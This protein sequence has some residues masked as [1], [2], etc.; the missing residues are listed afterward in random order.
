MKYFVVLL[1]T[2]DAEKS[3]EYRPQHLEYWEQRRKEGHIFANGRFKD[4]SGGMVIYMAES[5][6]QAKSFA[7]N[8]PF[9]I[10]KARSYEIHEWDI[11]TDAVIP[12]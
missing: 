11:V 12:E 10:H 9:V 8:D 4:G 3:N 6:E 1:P 5:Y 2:L 7:E